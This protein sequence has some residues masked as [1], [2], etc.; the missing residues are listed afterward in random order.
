MRVNVIFALVFGT[1]IIKCGI[2][3]KKA[4]ILSGTLVEKLHR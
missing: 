1:P 4:K 2:A 3:G